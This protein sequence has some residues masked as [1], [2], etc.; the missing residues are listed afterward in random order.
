MRPIIASTSILVGGLIVSATL[1]SA[2]PEAAPAMLAPDA[3]ASFRSREVTIPAGTLLRL[4]LQNRVASNASR[5]EDPVTATL[6]Q[7]VHVDGS[8][9]LPAGSTAHGYVT[10]ASPGGR[11]KGRAR[12]GVRFNSI[13]S[14]SDDERYRMTTSSWV[15]VARATKRNDALKIGAPAA[16]GAVIGA[17]L[18]GKKGAGIG[19]LVGGGAG[20]AVVL[21]T[22]GKQIAVRPGALLA[23]RLA[24]PL[25]VRVPM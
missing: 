1:L 15:A 11:V 17:L 6:A 21:T 22:R 16:G 14:A 9:V 24:A 12:V 7:T 5:V 20:T 19:A 18:G 8:A 4:R 25:T 2:T 10:T 13:T 3:R 23:V